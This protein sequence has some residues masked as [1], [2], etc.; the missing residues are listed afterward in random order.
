M[1]VSFEPSFRERQISTSTHEYDS[2]VDESTRNNSFGVLCPS[3]SSSD[4]DGD[5]VRT[6]RRKREG[7]TS[8]SAR[9]T[10]VIYSIRLTSL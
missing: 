9:R 3:G 7:R 8:Q 1:K 4:R 2:S 5:D 10:A 6:L